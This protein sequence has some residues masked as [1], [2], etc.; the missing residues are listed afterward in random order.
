MLSK[1]FR[2]VKTCNLKKYIFLDLN[3]EVLRSPSACRTSGA[4]KNRDYPDPK[5]G[6][7]TEMCTLMFLTNVM[8]SVFLI[9][10]TFSN[11]FFWHI[12]RQLFLTNFFD[13][14]NFFELTI[15]FW[16]MIFFDLMIFFWF[17]NFFLFDYLFLVESIFRQNFWRNIWRIFNHCSDQSTYDL[18]SSF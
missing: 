16:L 18:V 14:M 12:F 9:F 15:F 2:Q 10:Y 1:P 11:E 6:S 7:L 5:W 4:S 3:P 17:D 13:L 8:T